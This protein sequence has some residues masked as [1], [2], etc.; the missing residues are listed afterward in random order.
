M[1]VK[2][3]ITDGGY[4]DLGIHDQEGESE[5]FGFQILILLRDLRER[6][7][8]GQING[9]DESECIL[10]C[11]K[12]KKRRFARLYTNLKMWELIDKAIFL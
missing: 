11:I 1:E 9:Y 5:I 3:K 10:I 2:K 4:L 12:G 8:R 7:F 6:D